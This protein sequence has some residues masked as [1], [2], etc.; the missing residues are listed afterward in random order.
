MRRR[1]VPV[2]LFILLFVLAATAQTQT[3]P[4]PMP[5]PDDPKIVDRT[6][7]DKDGPHL[8]DEMLKKME[9]ARAEI[10]YKKVLDDVDKLNNL[11][12]ELAKGYTERK[13]LSAED[14]KKLGTI[15]KLAKRV[16]GYAGGD[17]FSDKESPAE[18]VTLA[19]AIEKLNTNA[20]D[21]KKDMK[22]ETRFVVSASVIAKSNEM[23]HL[24]RFIRRSQ[25]N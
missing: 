18:P 23:I 24:A 22:A 21:I 3:P 11:S 16:Q 20:A 19:E 4:R 7:D 10:E 15:E 9:I 5:R 17:E 2:A 13:N 14:V 8:P 1:F 12:N 25:K 6:K